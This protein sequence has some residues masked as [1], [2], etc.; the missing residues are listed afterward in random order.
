MA[1]GASTAE[2]QASAKA[3]ASV[4]SFQ[5]RRAVGSPATIR[6]ATSL[7]PATGRPETAA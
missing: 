6:S 5:I 7:A 3:S 2:V 4:A 1:C